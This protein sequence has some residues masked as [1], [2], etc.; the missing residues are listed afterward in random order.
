MTRAFPHSFIDVV[1]SHVDADSQNALVTVQGVRGDVPANSAA[2]TRNVAVECHF[3][4][5]ILT[6]FRWIS[7]PLHPAATGQTR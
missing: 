7:G 2:F 6:S 3:E 4:S 5:G 1:G